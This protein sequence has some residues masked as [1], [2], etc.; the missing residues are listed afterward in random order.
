[1]PGVEL[2]TQKTNNSNTTNAGM[3]PD[4]VVWAFWAKSKEKREFI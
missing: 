2:A 3:Y 1:M 4:A